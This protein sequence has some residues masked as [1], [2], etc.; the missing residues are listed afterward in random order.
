MYALHLHSEINPRPQRRSRQFKEEPS[1]KK[2]TISRKMKTL[3]N[4]I[5]RR[6]TI[7]ISTALTEHPVTRKPVG[8]SKLPSTPKQDKESSHLVTIKRSTARPRK[9]MTPKTEP[10]VKRRRVT[11]TSSTGN[12]KERTSLPS[13]PK[14]RSVAKAV[15]QSTQNTPKTPIHSEPKDYS[16]DIAVCFKITMHLRQK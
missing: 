13:T 6:N 9:P 5:K 4:N 10:R 12:S 7:A 15:L 2:T 11:S 14:Q 16:Q 8:R 1:T 3:Q